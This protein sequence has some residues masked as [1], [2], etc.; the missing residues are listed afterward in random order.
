MLGND[1]SINEGT[2][3]GWVNHWKNQRTARVPMNI[4]A[5]VSN[6]IIPFAFNLTESHLNIIKFWKS[7]YKRTKKLEKL[8]YYSISMHLQVKFIF[9]WI[10]R[11][12]QFKEMLDLMAMLKKGYCDGIKVQIG[13][14]QNLIS[15]SCIGITSCHTL[16]SCYGCFLH[17]NYQSPSITLIY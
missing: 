3:N 15:S 11:D 12:P 2:W 17:T 6:I 5:F 1:T 8:P 14:L 13:R 7:N 9:D 16:T 4:R 10:F